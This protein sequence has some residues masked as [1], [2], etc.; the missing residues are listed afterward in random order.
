MLDKLL[1]AGAEFV[2]GGLYYQGR[3]VGRST[4]D[5]LEMFEDVLTT[6]AASTAQTPLPVDEPAAPAKRG[7]KSKVAAVEDPDMDFSDLIDELTAK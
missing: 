1:A 6:P 2:S 3:L 5:G 7:R 4:V